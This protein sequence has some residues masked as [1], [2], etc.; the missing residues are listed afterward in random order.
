MYRNTWMQIDLDAIADNVKTIH[1]ICGKKFIAVLKAN[2]YGS[3]DRMI[4]KTVI[5]AGADMIAVSSLDEAIVLRN[6][7]YEGELL[8]LGNTEAADCRMMIEKNISAAAY[9]KHWVTEMTA[10]DCR[11]LKVHLKVDTGMN[12]IG[13]KDLDELVQAKKILLDAGCI[14]EGIFT[15]FACS[16]TDIDMTQRQYARFAAAV[17]AC[18]YPF[19]WIH[20]DNSEATLYFKDPVSNACRVG[21]SLYGIAGCRK[22]LKHA[23]SLYT[24]LFMVKK[25]KA[26]ETIG[27]GATYSAEHDEIIGTLPIGYADGWIRANQGRQVYA[28][29]MYATVVGRVCMDQ[30][31]IQMPQYKPE[32]TI[33]ELF[34][35]HISLC[36]MADQL[37]TIPYEI[38][39]LINSRVTRVYLSN[40]KEVLKE[41]ARL[42]ISEQ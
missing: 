41:N 1:Q 33:V 22:D 27:Y 10:Q 19:E 31:M 35:P 9:S 15:H 5:D 37:H 12:R 3:G 29:G 39:C 23:L 32:G 6:E 2:A 34:G 11:G 25:V 16:D 26:G 24:R 36:E 20:C 8:I 40:G 14:L 13:F 38:I 42:D 17:K 28:D 30:C 18:S 7:M 4:A 21:I